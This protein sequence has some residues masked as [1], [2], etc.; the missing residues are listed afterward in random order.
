MKDQRLKKKADAENTTQTRNE[1]LKAL[2]K[3]LT[4]FH[5]AA[6]LAFKDNPQM[7]EAFGI[8]VKS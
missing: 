8:K 1:S 6:R 2:R 5:A 3:W 4:E 7:L